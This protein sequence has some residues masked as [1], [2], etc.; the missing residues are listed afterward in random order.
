MAAALA[1]LTYLQQQGPEVWQRLNDRTSRL[2]GTLDAFAA[3]RDLPFRVPSFCSQFLLRV[4]TDRPL[5]TLLF[6]HLRD[7]GVYLQEGFPCYLTLA[8]TDADVDRVIEAV[9]DS[10]AELQAHDCF[11]GSA[12][13]A[14]AET[15]RL[16][17]TE[18]QQEIWLATR[19]GGRSSIA[20]N[21]SS[22]LHL[23]GPLRID[24]LRCALLDVAE[25]HEALRMTILADGQSQ[26]VAPHGLIALDE[27]LADEHGADAAD[28]AAR[29]VRDGITPFDLERGPL[30]RASILRLEPHHHILVFT[31]HHIVCDGWSATKLLTEIGARYSAIVANE[32][33]TP[34]PAAIPFRTLAAWQEQHASSPAGAADER[35]WL[36]M[37]SG[38]LPALE[39]PLDRPHPPQRSFRG[40]REEL[41]IDPA[42]LDRLK[43]LSARAGCTLVTTQLAAFEVLLHRLTGQTDFIVGLPASEHTIVGTAGVIG[44]GTN[45]LPLRVTIAS[46]TAFDRQLE[47][48]KRA[49]LDAD[50]HRHCTYGRLLRQLRLTRSPGRLP[51][52]EVLFNIDRLDDDLRFHGLEATI[53]DNERQAFNF[54]FGLNCVQTGH[55]LLLQ[56]DYSTDLLDAETVR[57]WLGH[58]RTI[59]DAIADNP[60]GK[61]GALPLMTAADRQRLV[62]AWNAPSEAD[63]DLTPATDRDRG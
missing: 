44:H 48:V 39:L 59:L 7:R 56:G 41:T 51:L 58:F 36:E 1:T 14:R 55:S 27:W 38:D 35:Y 46:S 16:P 45:L 37:L 60:S 20:Y 54:D 6:Y 57:R 40:A 50:E 8:H 22:V 13:A 15:P 23:R 17:L 63:V 2:A 31:T 53:A 42:L 33:V 25:R 29:V 10:A 21:E 12:G 34:L 49:L 32:G 28:I 5:A 43:R 61:V 3:E 24:A 52:V 18:A 9:M 62:M 11:V 19:S 47:T 26:V 4:Q 30:A